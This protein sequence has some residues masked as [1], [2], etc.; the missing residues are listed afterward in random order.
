MLCSDVAAVTVAVAVVVGDSAEE[1]KLKEDAE[2]LPARARGGRLNG[3]GNSLAWRLRLTASPA[4]AD[5]WGVL[6]HK[7]PATPHQRSRRSRRCA[8]VAPRYLL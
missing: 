2:A 3:T 1:D 7:S 4:T 6:S 5:N 8:L